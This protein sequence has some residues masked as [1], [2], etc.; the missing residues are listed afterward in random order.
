MRCTE[1]NTIVGV[2]DRGNKCVNSAMKTSQLFAITVFNN[3][4]N[5]DGCKG[6]RQ[7][8]DKTVNHNR[9]FIYSHGLLIFQ[10]IESFVK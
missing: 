10:N 3:P 4:I 8:F 1:F 7:I 5:Q 9:F 2:V 6:K